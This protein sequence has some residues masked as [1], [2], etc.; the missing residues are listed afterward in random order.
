MKASTT[1]H[2]G[3]HMSEKTI[4]KEY[5]NE[6]KIEL[7]GLNLSGTGN[8]I[9]FSLAETSWSKLGLGLE[10]AHTYPDPNA[11]LRAVTTGWSKAVSP[12]TWTGKVQTR[13]A[14]LL[15]EHGLSVLPPDEYKPSSTWSRV[16]ESLEATGSLL[17][18]TP[19]LETKPLLANAAPAAPM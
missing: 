6:Q 3:Y 11:Y 2:Q 13:L 5:L 18:P 10:L 14:T 19:L 4:S 8:T 12:I 9:D 7:L 15:E 1:Y 16:C 17:G